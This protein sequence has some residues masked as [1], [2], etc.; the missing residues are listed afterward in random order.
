M[1]AKVKA[2]CTSCHNVSRITE[3]HLTRQGWSGELKKMEGLGAVVSDADR[4]AMLSYLVKHF[5]PEK[6]AVKKPASAAN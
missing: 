1:Q 3:Q 5:G 4:N 2:A 6:T